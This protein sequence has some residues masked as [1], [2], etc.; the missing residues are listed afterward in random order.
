MIRSD[1][2][3]AA[4]ASGRKSPCVSEITPTWISGMLMQHATSVAH[5]TNV[6][7][8]M[9]DTGFGTIT[10]LLFVLLSSAH[11]LGHLFTRLRQP[12]VA[13]GGLPS[14]AAWPR[15]LVRVP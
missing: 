10:L 4:T 15:A 9:S 12:R 2:R 14:G 5:L 3:R 7:S 11:I 8:T 6:N 13:G 1:P